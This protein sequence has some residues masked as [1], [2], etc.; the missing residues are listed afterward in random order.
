MPDTLTINTGEGN[1]TITIDPGANLAVKVN[2][3]SSAFTDRLTV[4]GTT[5]DDTIGVDISSQSVT[6]NMLGA[7]NYAG[8]EHLTVNGGGTDGSSTVDGDD[9]A[10]MDL[11]AVNGLQTLT[12]NLSGIAGTHA[13]TETL[14]VTSTA[15][16]DVIDVQPLS[17][18]SGTVQA[19][20]VGP[21]VTFTGLGKTSSDATLTVAGGGN[22]DT[23]RVHGTNAVE[24]IDVDGTM[25]AVGVLQTVTY[26]TLEA[27]KVY[28]SEGDDLF[29]VTAAGIP[30][31]IDG[32]DPIGGGTRGD[33]LN[34]LAGG[35]SVVLN[36]GPPIDEGSLVAGANA[37]VSYDRIEALGAL[38]VDV[39][40]INA[41]NDADAITIIARSNTTAY[42]ALIGKTPGVKDFT[43]S[44]NDGIEVLFVDT[45][46]LIVNALGGSDEITVRTPAALATGDWDVDVTINGGTP[47]AGSDQLVVETPGQ[48]DV[49][50]R[51]G[52][53][54]DSGVLVIDQMTNPSTVTIKEIEHFIYDGEAGNDTFEHRYG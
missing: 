50:Y 36:A 25:V 37:P 41:T 6:V 20:G 1:D 3:G 52:T 12:V 42:P 18:T 4:N 47:S 30:I 29:K 22:D 14:V 9:F 19:N 16:T 40:T 15:G 27:L 35:A 46:T 13:A 32:G 23:L 28:G 10:L 44:V 21:V 26:N 49:I 31:F 7:V 11:G 24:T 33:V 2:G 51:P 38:T 17:A 43:V 53:T 5:S 54:P 45:P 34:L 39:A 8:I 48:N